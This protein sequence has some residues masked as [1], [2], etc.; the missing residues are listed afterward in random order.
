MIGL[1]IT[2]LLGCALVYRYGGLTGQGPRWA[3]WLLVAGIGIGIGIGVMG[4]LFFAVRTVPYATLALAA[5]LPG[6]LAWQIRRMPKPTAEPG[7]INGLLAS[8]L[9]VGLAIAI[10]AMTH[11][12]ATNPQGNWDAFSI[13]NLRAQ[14]FAS[15]ELY[16][17][18]WSPMLKFT[19]PEYPMLLSSFVAWCWRYSGLPE[20]VPIATS[21]LFF[22]GLLCAGI[23]GLTISRSPALGLAY[24]LV[25]ATSPAFLHEVPAQYADV[26][27][28]YFFATAVLMAILN[29]PLLAGALA[30]MASFTKNE[31]AVFFVILLIIVAVSRRGVVA[32]LAGSLPFIAMTAVFKFV[33]ATGLEGLKM[34][35]PNTA[36]LSEIIWGFITEFLNLG[37]GFYHP[38]MPVIALAVIWGIDRRYR[39]ESLRTITIAIVM[40]AVYFGIILFTANDVQWQI[41]TALTRLYAQIWPTLLLGCILLIKSPEEA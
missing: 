7:R 35:Q 11:A 3:Q 6:W 32:F 26:P 15:D 36:Q 8:G 29:R 33:L 40:L 16:A 27:L 21:L 1:I 2:V 37:S 9:L 24:G 12:W 34:G 10:A 31:G 22:L 23:G 19:H 39:P 5:L 20:S 38:L 13:W 18:A 4:S 14:F 41:G 25:L 17:R 30:G 28:A